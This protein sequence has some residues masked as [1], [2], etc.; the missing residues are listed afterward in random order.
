MDVIRRDQRE[1]GEKK[2]GM[3]WGRRER[4][5]REREIRRTGKKGYERKREA[6][7]NGTPETYNS[8]CCQRRKFTWHCDWRTW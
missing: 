5:G 8:G 4:Q 1:E 3:G 6:L 2:E 7:W